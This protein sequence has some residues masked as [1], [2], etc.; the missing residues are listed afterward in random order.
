MNLKT[1]VGDRSSKGIF[2]SKE[3]MTNDYEMNFE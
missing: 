1:L 3:I 2:E